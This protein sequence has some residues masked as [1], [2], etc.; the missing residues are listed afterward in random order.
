MLTRIPFRFR[1]CSIRYTPYISKHNEG[2]QQSAATAEDHQ[3]E[4]CFRP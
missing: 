4:K 3:L 2:A 1:V